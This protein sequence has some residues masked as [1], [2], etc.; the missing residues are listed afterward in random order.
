MPV[1]ETSRRERKVVR[2][3]RED[4]GTWLWNRS[5]SCNCCSFALELSNGASQ[6]L[7]AV[8][9]AVILCQ[10]DSVLDWAFGVPWAS[11][12]KVK[13]G[14][15][16][17]MFPLKSRAFENLVPGLIVWEGWGAWPCWR[18][19][20]HWGGL[21]VS[22]ALCHPQGSLSACCL[23]IRMWALWCCPAPC[24]PSAM[25]SAVAVMSSY[26]LDHT[27]QMN[28]SFSKLPW[29]FITAT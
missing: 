22:K 2:F 12:R 27:P 24:L 5:W 21:R 11:T 20:C 16:N 26:P 7:S 3:L 1:V 19:V 8:V 18:E 10:V 25:H 17:E 13:Y 29:C 14:G 28:S 9:W 15:L 6:M 4:G 23:W